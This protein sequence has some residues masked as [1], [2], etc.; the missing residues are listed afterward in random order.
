MKICVFGAGAIGGHVAARL[1]RGGA[2]VSVVARGAQLD[3]IR[4][5][6]LTV[7]AED[8]RFTVPV[9]ASADPAAL[10]PQDAVIVTVKAPSLPSVA[11]AIAPLRAPVTPVAFVMNGIPWWYFHAH[12][13]P[14]DGQRLPRIDPGGAMWDAVGPQN[15][16][17]GVVYSACTVTEPGTVAVAG[18]YNRIVLGEPDGRE[19]PR[20]A[21]I[22]EALRAGGWRIDVTGR[23]RDA[24]W[25]K[26][27]LNLYSGLLSIASG[28][29]PLRT[30]MED[31]AVA[32]AARRL[33]EEGQAVAA[34][35]GCPVSLN[36]DRLLAPQSQ[37]A[38]TPSIVQDLKRG[39]P[40][41][42]EALYQAPLAMARQA[43]VATPTLDLLVAV[44]RH[45]AAAAGLYDP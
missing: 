37:A 45:R 30:L 21:A 20:V 34:A 44:A 22:A 9:A 3:A 19:T 14:H 41:E 33:V 38:H 5:K 31:P 43:G 32:A 12:G 1:A 7:Q 24:I 10:G 36:I 2:E 16:I 39:R 28:G 27:M 11:A 35:M 26:L 17:G 42:I 40:M 6:G 18:N 13:G 15:A 8:G 25:S 23:I 29:A 4:A